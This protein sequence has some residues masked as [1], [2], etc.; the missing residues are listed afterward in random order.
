MADDKGYKDTKEFT[1][2]GCGKKIILTKFASQKTCKCDEC[3]A[4]NVPINR[5][6]VEEAL[7]NNGPKVRQKSEGA[8]KI[9]NCINCGKPTEVSKFM[10]ASKVLCDVWKGTAV[11]TDKYV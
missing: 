3:K 2:T 7:K 1:C 8:T 4:N 10:S 5:Q 9:C 6:I 11:D